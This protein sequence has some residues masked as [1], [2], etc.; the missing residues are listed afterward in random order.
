MTQNGEMRQAAVLQLKRE[1]GMRVD[2]TFTTCFARA[3]CAFVRAG[4]ASLFDQAEPMDP[5]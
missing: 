4:L 2:P 1:I 5:Q 3:V